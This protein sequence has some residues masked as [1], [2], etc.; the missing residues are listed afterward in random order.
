MKIDLRALAFPMFALALGIIN[1]TGIKATLMAQNQTEPVSDSSVYRSPLSV[2]ISPDNQSIYV[3]DCTAGNL[4]IFGTADV[5]RR[6][7]VSLRGKPLGMALTPDGRQLYVAERGAGSV[8]VIDTAQREISSRIAVG[9]WPTAVA[10]A[11]KTKRLYVCNQDDH[12][13]SVVDLKE[14]PPKPIKKISVVREPSVAAITPDERHVVIANLLA[15]GR[16]TDPDLAAEVSIVDTASLTQSAKVKLP[17]GSTMVRGLCLSPD[18][19]W[20]YVVHG[21]GRFNLPITQLERGWVN[22]Y[23]ISIIDIDRGTRLATVLL[24]DLTQGAADPHSVVCS[25][26]GSRLWISHA[27]VHEVSIVEIGLLH[28]LLD[29][30]VPAELASL[31]DGTQANIWVRI[32]QDPNV[33]PEL[34]N[35]LTALYIAGAIRRV[36]SGGIGPRGLALSADDK[37]LFVANYYS[38]SVVMLDANSGKQQGELTLGSQ[39]QIDSVRRG[40]IIFHDATLSF[41]R[42]HSCASCH[43]NEGRVDGLRW[44]FLNDGIGNPKDTISLVFFHQT[45]PMNRR[46]TGDSARECV[47]GGLEGT[48]MLV[49]KKQDVD[50]LFDYMSSLRPE[51]SPHLTATGELT[52]AATRGKILFEGK[53]NCKSCHPAPYFTDKQMHNVGVLSDHYKEKD[54]RFDTPSLIEVF[55]TAPYLHDGRALTIKEIFTK[56]DAEGKHGKAKQLTEQELNDLAKYLQSL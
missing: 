48:N 27:G 24:D 33:I 46:A 11:A 41:Q 55:R 22:T 6:T 8:A 36:P 31:K 23:A 2:A 49:S 21:L 54:S 4:V 40:E 47:K 53:A 3:T 30:K 7:E 17:I 20:A 32:Q 14:Q 9:K 26:D 35:H 50:D 42:W 12:S 19:R 52:E 13:V 18:G 34:E 1:L 15:N 25:K 39:P 51:R 29:G 56:H 10:V 16:G 37:T 5:P 38:G 28:Q 43:A 44:D 45:E